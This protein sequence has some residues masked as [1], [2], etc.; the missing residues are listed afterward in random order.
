MAC[1]T[2]T[3]QIGEH[4]YSVT[5]FPAEKAMITK[6]KLIKCL[7]PAFAFLSSVE[8]GDEEKEFSRA[9]ELLFENSSPEDIV[10][11]VKQCVV[12]VARDGKKM[13]EADFNSYFSGDELLNAYKVFFFVLEVNYANLIPGRMSGL[14]AKAK[15]NL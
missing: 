13:I 1:E 8:K 15:E 4:E 14:L 7:G 11:L 9:I 5:Q 2:Q 6:L 12:G 3:K 10:A